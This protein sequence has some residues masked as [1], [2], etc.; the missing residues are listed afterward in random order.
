MDVEAPVG[1]RAWLDGLELRD[2][3]EPIGGEMFR[4]FGSRFLREMGDASG[5][6]PD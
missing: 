2:V 3:I 5:T 4:Q 6:D 1:G